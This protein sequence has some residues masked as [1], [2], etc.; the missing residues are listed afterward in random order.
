LVKPS[1]DLYQLSTNLDGTSSLL[2][3][4]K[5]HS[6]RRY[7][8]ITLLKLTSLRTVRKKTKK[9]I[10]QPALK[11]YLLQFQPNFPKRSMKSPSIL[12]QKNPHQLK[13]I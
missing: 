10:N 13:Q 5:I 6:N 12:R 1:G 8:F 9:L 2:T 3:T 11:D 7:H 4:T